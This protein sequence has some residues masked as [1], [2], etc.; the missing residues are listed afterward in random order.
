MYNA[1]KIGHKHGNAQISM[2]RAVTL[3]I[4]LGDRIMSTWIK[5]Q[6][7]IQDRIP[8]FLPGS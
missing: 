6:T 1:K 8:I 2:E 4:T 7:K 3:D 5:K